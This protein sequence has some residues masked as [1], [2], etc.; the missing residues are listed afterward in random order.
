MAKR[1]L[2]CGGRAN[3]RAYVNKKLTQYVNENG[4][5]AVLIHG[6]GGNTDLEAKN[7]ACQNGV[8]MEEYPAEWKVYG[9]S[10]GPIRNQYMLENGK[11]EVVLAF[12]GGRG[13]A[14]M[15]ER[16]RKAGV[17]INEIA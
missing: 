4:P 3:D 14:D 6:A 9:K 15:K 12:A 16:A 8:K 1:V 5:I 11:P 13:T 7:W 2:V 17:P 10:A